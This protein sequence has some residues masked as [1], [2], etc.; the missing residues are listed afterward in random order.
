MQHPPAVLPTPFDFYP[1]ALT[2]DHG[3]GERREDRVND[4]CFTKMNGKYTSIRR[5]NLGEKIHPTSPRKKATFHTRQSSHSFFLGSKNLFLLFFQFY[6]IFSI[7]FLSFD[8][9]MNGVTHECRRAAQI[10]RKGWC[11]GR[12]EGGWGF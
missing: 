5:A 7:S 9:K 4:S 12:I 8:F 11:E 1:H 6:Y 3:N 2:F 10:L